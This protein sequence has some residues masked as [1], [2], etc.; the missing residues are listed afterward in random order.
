MTACQENKPTA[1]VPLD[2]A[3]RFSAPG[4]CEATCDLFQTARPFAA[5]RQSTDSANFPIA[6]GGATIAGL[7]GDSVRLKLAADTALLT[8]LGRAGRV[9]ISVAA[10]GTTTV[11]GISLDSLIRGAVVYRFLNGTPQTPDTVQLTYSLPRVFGSVSPS[12]PARLTQYLSPASTAVAWS[13]PWSSVSAAQA[14]LSSQSMATC[15]IGAPGA[16]CGISVGIQPYAPAT[17]WGA[18]QSNRGTGQS[19]GITITFSAPIS[20]VTITAEDPTFAGNSMT[21]YNAAGAALGTQAFAYSGVP[22][23]NIPSTQT[24][25]AS[26]IRRVELTAPIGEYVAYD[27]IVFTAGP[28]TP[29]VICPSTVTRGGMMSCSTNGVAVVGTWTFNPDPVA[30]VILTDVTETMNVANA[31]WEGTVA[32]SGAVAATGWLTIDDFLAHKPAQLITPA[33]VT[34]TAR[35]WA[36]DVLHFTELPASSGHGTLPTFPVKTGTGYE[37][38]YG[39]FTDLGI[40]PF[41]VVTIL[42]GPN[43]FY[44]FI[45]DPSSGKPAVQLKQPSVFLNQALDG[46]GPW[47]ALHATGSYNGISVDP[48]SGLPYCTLGGFAA[49]KPHVVRHEGLTGDPDS[50]Y[51]YYDASFRQSHLNAQWE[52]LVGLENIDLASGVVAALDQVLTMYS[53]RQPQVALDERDNTDV[54]HQWAGNCAFIMIL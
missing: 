16:A 17:V 25:S 34:V 37:M 8:A 27:A 41:G 22:G 10:N 47:A 9:D 36:A 49:M 4:A 18:F 15:T 32:A 29:Q 53:T 44:R 48:S 33:H 12:E 40:K 21:A 6:I 28:S 42:G 24:I 26:G 11:R 50:H 2:A 7:V 54:Q 51:G 35:Q 46:N 19:Y 31:T 3:A 45:A 38:T 1:P 20:S 23:V 13:A 14:S 5:A 30:N 43:Q 52:A 39:K